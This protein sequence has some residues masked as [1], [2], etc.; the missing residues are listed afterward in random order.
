MSD[1]QKAAAPITRLDPLNYILFEKLFGE[2]G[3]EPQ[4]LELLKPILARTE[5]DLRSI[6][7]VENKIQPPEVIGGKGGVLDLRAKMADGSRCNIEVQRQNQ[8]NM[9]RR[10]LYYWAREYTGSIVS[11]QNYKELP[12]VI[13]INILDF[14]YIPLEDF[15][16][17]FHLR[18]DYHREYKLTNAQEVHFLELPKFRKLAEKN[19]ADDPLHRWLSYLDI[20]TPLPLIKEITEMDP[21]I[22]HT[23]E[24][25]E[26]LAQDEA[27]RHAYLLYDMALSDETSRLE[28]AREEGIEKGME[29]ALV[30]TARNLLSMGLSIEQIAKGTGLSDEIIR[31]L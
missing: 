12:D 25:S 30:A 24:L 23:Q 9:E 14:T 4:L 3:D 13:V 11:G 8:H 20:A 26:R 28:D 15:H 31:S 16:T 10:S 19:L 7:I 21:V 27:V 17:S 2:K 18:E 5:R 1:I 29:E 6:E 22:A